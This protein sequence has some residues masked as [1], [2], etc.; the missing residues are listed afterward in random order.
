MKF[1]RRL[2]FIWKWIKRVKDH[3]DW[4]Y[5]YLLDMEYYKICDMAKWWKDN[6]MG[7]AMTGPRIYSQLCLARDLLEI[8][9]DRA[10]YYEMK[11]K[12][13]SLIKEKDLLSWEPKYDWIIH[14]YVN[15]QN[16]KRY[17]KLSP[18]DLR[19]QNL[20]KIEL[21]KMKAWHIYNLLRER[22]MQD[23]WD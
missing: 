8:I 4:D 12:E 20:Y 21:Y 1:I 10:D 6:D 5:G 14:R 11:E 7:H 22:Y 18:S 17:W 3:Y 15:V 19:D 2:R 13:V 16:S 23:W 9:T